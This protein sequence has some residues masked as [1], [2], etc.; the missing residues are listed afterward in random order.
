[1]MMNDERDELVLELSR[2]LWSLHMAGY[3]F[4]KMVGENKSLNLASAPR[5]TEI[6]ESRGH[7]I[8]SETDG[9]DGTMVPSTE[10]NLVEDQSQRSNDDVTIIE[11]VSDVLGVEVL[12]STHTDVLMS[13]C[14]PLMPMGV[15]EVTAADD[16]SDLG[17]LELHEANDLCDGELTMADLLPGHSCNNSID[18]RMMMNSN[19]A[20]R[21]RST[22]GAC[23]ERAGD[24]A[25]MSGSQA[26]HGWAASLQRPCHP[27]GTSRSGQF[28]GRGCESGHEW[29]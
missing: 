29:Y 4:E 14:A 25:P 15:R 7:A 17:S 27:P 9:N 10:A 21:A 11:N 24:R 3:H 19:E 22:R 20:E 13:T 12:N 1:M 8:L 18:R 26:N 6:L 28:T 16:S 23:A 2:S 5:S